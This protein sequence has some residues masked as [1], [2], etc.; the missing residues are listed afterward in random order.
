MR[1]RRLIIRT[2]KMKT[3]LLLKVIICL[4]GVSTLGIAAGC[5]LFELTLHIFNKSIYE[6]FK[7][8]GS[9][10][11]ALITLL[12]VWI[13][14]LIHK[15]QIKHLTNEKKESLYRKTLSCRAKMP[16]ALSKLVDYTKEC[17][18]YVEAIHR[19]GENVNIPIQPADALF[20]FTESIEF[21]DNDAAQSAFELVS[22][23]QVIDARLRNH[24]YPSWRGNRIVDIVRLDWLVTRLFDYARNESQSVDL[25]PLDRKRAHQSLRHIMGEDVYREADKYNELIAII[26]ERWEK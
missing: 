2:E 6:I 1:F 21:I 25:I 16:Q 20:T 7:D 5:Y 19:R 11:G 3:K 26:D 10:I 23:C 22:F 17:Y 4:L 18:S 15:R 12:A 13:A 8:Q 9:I 14:W 24:N